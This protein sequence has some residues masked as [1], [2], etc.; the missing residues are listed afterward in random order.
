MD[1]PTETPVRHLMM[2]ITVPDKGERMMEAQ[3]G[4]M[5]A[6]AEALDPGHVAFAVEPRE[7]S[8]DERAQLLGIVGAAV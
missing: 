2:V 7:I 3:K 1:T 5:R 8:A 6:A 4:Y